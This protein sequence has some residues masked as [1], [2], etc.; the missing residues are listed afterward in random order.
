M[1][2]HHCTC[3]ECDAHIALAA[4]NM[5]ALGAGPPGTLTWRE[6]PQLPDQ[7]TVAAMERANGACAYP[8]LPEGERVPRTLC[9]CKVALAAAD[10]VRTLAALNR[11]GS[12][13]KLQNEIVPVFLL[14][15]HACGRVWNHFVRWHL[16]AASVCTLKP[17]W[18]LSR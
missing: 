12:C 7:S 5:F 9:L 1:V 10:S 13:A 3:Q 11:P 2:S 18:A 6:P 8:C 14:G 15:H 17:P 4:S 16:D